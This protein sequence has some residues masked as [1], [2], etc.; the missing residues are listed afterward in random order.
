MD[1]MNQLTTTTYDRFHGHLSTQAQMFLMILP[2]NFNSN[3]LWKMMLGRRS[4]PFEM[5]PFQGT[6][7]NFCGCTT[8]FKK[9]KA[10]VTETNSNG[11]WKRCFFW[12]FGLFLVANVGFR[13]GTF[14]NPANPSTIIHI[15]W[16]PIL[17]LSQLFYQM[18]YLSISCFLS[19]KICSVLAARYVET[20]GCA[21]TYFSGDGENVPHESW[22]LIIHHFLVS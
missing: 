12:G 1:G 7:Y 22:D 6:C 20:K 10:G 13:E 14:Q 15:P 18:S 4:F 19:Q 11:V 21:E 2:E 5:I 8:N 16:M 17:L 3:S 9:N